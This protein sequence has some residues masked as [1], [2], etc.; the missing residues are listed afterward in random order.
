MSEVY[1]VNYIDKTSITSCDVVAAVFSTGVLFVVFCFDTQAKP[2]ISRKKK[3][4]ENGEEG[5]IRGMISCS[6]FVIF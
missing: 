4:K 3:S 1:R 5:F 2:E 6:T